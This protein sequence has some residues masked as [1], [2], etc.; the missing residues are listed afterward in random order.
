M[1]VTSGTTTKLRITYCNQRALLG[2][3]IQFGYTLGF[4]VTIAQEPGFAFQI[5]CCVRV[6]MLVRM[7][8][9]LR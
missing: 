3:L 7:K 9:I 8:R 6:Q 1:G 5:W 2:Y 4:G